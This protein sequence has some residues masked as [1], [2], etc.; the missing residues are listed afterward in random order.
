MGGFFVSPSLE[1]MNEARQQSQQLYCRTHLNHVTLQSVDIL[2]VFI[3][4]LFPSTAV[5]FDW[6]LELEHLGG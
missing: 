6:Q 1:L 3:V 5:L 2:S 4:F